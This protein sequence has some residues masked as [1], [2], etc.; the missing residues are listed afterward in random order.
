MHCWFELSGWQ[1]GQRGGKLNINT[2]KY[3]KTSSPGP[4]SYSAGTHSVEVC[5]RP[6]L[7]DLA[8]KDG[9]C[10]PGRLG[11]RKGTSIN[12][13]FTPC[14][15]LYLSQPVLIKFVQ[16]QNWHVALQCKL[17]APL[18]IP[19][20]EQRHSTPQHIVRSMWGSHAEGSHQ[21]TFNSREFPGPRILLLFFSVGD[22]SFLGASG[23]CQG[24]KTQRPRLNS[25]KLW[26]AI[27]AWA[28]CGIEADLC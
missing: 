25:G 15:G 10:G 4:C 27:I 16:W 23:Q 17:G 6:L 1:K 21:R 3:L 8:V 20:S 18:C 5:V 28:L 22:V 2:G 13:V 26:R 7:E 24:T 19:F 14:Q 11:P 9:A 12:R